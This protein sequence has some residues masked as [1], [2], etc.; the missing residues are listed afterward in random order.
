MGFWS[1]FARCGTVFFIA[2]STLLSLS[3]KK[4]KARGNVN[5]ETLITM[6]SEDLS[7]TVSKN[8]LKSYHFTT[9][10]MQQYGL[11]AE[12]YTK[13]PDGVFVQTFQD[14]TEVVESTLRA[15]EAINY[16]KRDLW[17]ASGHVVASGSGNTLYT[18]QLFWDAKTDRVYSNV[19]VKVVDKDGE[20]YGEGFESDKDLKSWMFRD[21]EGTIAVETAPNEEYDGAAGGSS[22]AS[23]G[24][25]TVPSGGRSGGNGYAPSRR[26]VLSPGWNPTQ[27]GGTLRPVPALKEG[28]PGTENVFRPESGGGGRTCGVNGLGNCHSGGLVAVVGVL[29]RHGDSVHQFQQAQTRDRP[30]TGRSVRQDSRRVHQQP[31]SVYH[32]HAG[33][34]QHRVGA[35]FAQHD[36]YHSC[37]G[38]Y[39]GAAARYGNLVGTARIADIHRHHHLRRGSS[40]RRLSSSCGPM[41]TSGL[42]P[43]RS[44]SFISCSIR[45]RSSLP[46]C[47]SV[48]CACSV[49]ESRTATASKVSKR[50]TWRIC[51]RRIPRRSRNRRTKSESFKMPSIFR[52]SLSGTAWCRAWMWKRSM[53]RVPSARYTAGSSRANIP[54]SSYGTVR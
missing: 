51:W 24:E 49:S 40:L 53:W 14:S 20:H 45:L 10:L 28:D 36:G 13:Y 33:G 19:R 2:G 16:E 30:Q 48:C 43:C 44:I 1:T 27:G 8:G 37:T 39:V 7:M 50:W 17:M 9:P 26:Q 41:P 22:D 32:H 35:L 23:A 4:E 6:Q 29:L 25:Q 11:A 47:R 42:S 15:D 21:Y 3:C 38:R 18:E 12:P 54:V 46:G 34:E 5:P 31:R 52:I